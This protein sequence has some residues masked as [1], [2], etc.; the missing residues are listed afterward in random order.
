[1]LGVMAGGQVTGCLTIR[2]SHL[3]MYSVTGC[4]LIYILL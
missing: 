2:G 3:Y 4:F 1:M